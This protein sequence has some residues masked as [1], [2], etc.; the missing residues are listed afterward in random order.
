[1]KL[2]QG[3]IYKLNKLLIYSKIKAIIKKKPATKR[4][5]TGPG[6]FSGQFY[7]TIKELLS[8]LLKLF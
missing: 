8:I 7:Q 2:N 5:S 3:H 1:M 6:V 4:Q